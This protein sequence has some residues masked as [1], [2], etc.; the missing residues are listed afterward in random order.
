[1]VLGLQKKIMVMILCQES[2]EDRLSGLMFW[3]HMFDSLLFFKAILS[4][5]PPFI[6][7]YKLHV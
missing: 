6:F 1:M 7:P 3:M 4:L 2:I 5:V